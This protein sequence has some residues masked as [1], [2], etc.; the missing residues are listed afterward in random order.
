MNLNEENKDLKQK[1]AGALRELDN[2]TEQLGKAQEIATELKERLDEKKHTEQL[3]GWAI[4]RAIETAKLSINPAS[5]TSFISTHETITKSAEAFC[6]W[7][8]QSS[9]RPNLKLVG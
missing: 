5:G 1:L 3:A 7:V 9:A 2:V 6:N 8:I 4:D